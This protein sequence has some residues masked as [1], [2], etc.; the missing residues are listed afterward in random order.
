[1]CGKCLYSF[2]TCDTL[3]MH[4]MTKHA[5]E[6][7]RSLL[8]CDN[9]VPAGKGGRWFPCSARLMIRSSTRRLASGVGGGEE[10][11]GEGTAKMH[12]T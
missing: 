7:V 6:T 9:L 3:A 5:N 10:V 8:W 11:M 2:D 4:M 12:D 1:M